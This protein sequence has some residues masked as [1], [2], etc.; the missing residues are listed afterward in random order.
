MIR[1]RVSALSVSRCAVRMKGAGAHERLS[2]SGVPFQDDTPVPVI[3]FPDINQEMY[4]MLGLRD[5]FRHNLLSS[6]IQERIGYLQHHT[7]ERIMARTSKGIY[8]N[9]LIQD[10]KLFV[11][12]KVP[13]KG[14]T[15]QRMNSSSSTN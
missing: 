5:G 10:L 15:L 7:T 12:C 4:Q 6:V 8:D 1:A 9:G 13:I 11:T 2:E 14:N 3:P